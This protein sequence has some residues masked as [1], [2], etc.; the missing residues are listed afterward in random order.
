[1][2]KNYTSQDHYDVA[3]IGGG[4][5]GLAAAIEAA[6]AGCHVALYERRK[7]VGG[8]RDGGCGF[9]GVESSVQKK[10]NNPLTKQE[11]F[12]FMMEHT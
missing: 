4:P 10:E 3:I 12:E 11:A 6:E 2:E 9:F 5:A 8:A 7:N 1:M